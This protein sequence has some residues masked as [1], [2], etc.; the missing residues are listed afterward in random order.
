MAR[1]ATVPTVLEQR[2]GRGDRRPDHHDAEPAASTGIGP[3][4]S[5]SQPPTGRMITATTT[6][7]AIRF[8]AS[9]GVSP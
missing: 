1:N 5:D 8:A 4:R 2:G 6:K 7:P 3:N 9:A